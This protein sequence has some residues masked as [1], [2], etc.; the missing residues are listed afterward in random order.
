MNNPII[1]IL[2]SE[3]LN[4]ENFVNLK[5]NMNIILICENYKFILTEEFSPWLAANAPCTVREAYD[6]WIG[7]NNKARYYILVAMSDVL[8]I[9]CGKIETAY[10]IIDSLQGMFGQPSIQLCHDAF[11]AAMNANMEAKTFVWEHVLK[12]IN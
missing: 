3:K 6:H 5:S 7:A 1:A 10:E 8:R 4:S 2:S 12:M 9:K 11:K